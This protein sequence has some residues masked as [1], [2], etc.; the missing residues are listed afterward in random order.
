MTEFILSDQYLYL[1]HVLPH[2]GPPGEGEGE[3]EGQ[4]GGANFK[5]LP[6]YFVINH[7]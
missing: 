6:N 4:G 7:V 5:L 3:G 1:L 2:P